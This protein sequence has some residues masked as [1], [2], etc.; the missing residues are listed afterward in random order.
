MTTVIE[1]QSEQ[2]AAELRHSP[3]VSIVIPA[4][5]EEGA[6]AED[7][8]ALKEE[9]S[10][11]GLDYEV[12]VVNDG[13]KDNTAAEAA[14]VDGVDIISHEVNRGYGAALKTGIRNARADIVVIT[15]ADGTYPPRYI[16]ELVQ[17]VRD[18]AD[19]AVG[20]RVGSSVAIPTIRKPAKWVLAKLASYLAEQH[21]PDLN[22]GLRAF[23]KDAVARFFNILPNGF[24]FTT[25]ITLGMLT[26]GYRVVYRPID[27]LHRV[28][29]SKIRPIK[30]TYNFIVLILRTICYFNP[31][32]VFVPPAVFCTI[33]GLVKLIHGVFWEHDISQGEMMMLL[34][35][36]QLLGTGM[37]AEM[38]SKIITGG[39]PS[40]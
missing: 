4:Y 2:Q 26:N 25:T 14:K 37:V 34:A 13:S 33:V 8:A 17:D 31:L 10:A 19:M 5:N 16:P 36:A 1:P 6:I 27:Y 23:R 40:K 28:G 20:A 11:I 24:S 30:D 3:E 39:T 38:V 21:I 15:D 7:L 12:I 9:L 35:A 18:G 32:R 29:S 22:S